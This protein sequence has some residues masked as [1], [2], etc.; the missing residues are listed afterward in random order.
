MWGEISF[1]P[2]WSLGVA[3]RSAASVKGTLPYPVTGT[4][5]MSVPLACKPWRCS[6][7]GPQL[8]LRTTP[9]RTR[10]ALAWLEA[11]TSL[12]DPENR[13]GVAH[14]SGRWDESDV[15][16]FPA[17]RTRCRCSNQT[18][19]GSEDDTT[20]RRL[21]VHPPTV[22]H[23]RA[24]PP[25]LNVRTPTGGRRVQWLIPSSKDNLLPCKAKTPFFSCSHFSGQ[26]SSRARVKSPYVSTCSTD[27]LCSTTA[28]GVWPRHWP[29]PKETRPFQAQVDHTPHCTFDRPLPIGSF[30]AMSWA[31]AMR[32]WFLM[33]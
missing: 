7:F 12:H 8:A 2:L 15:S 19:H 14:V 6:G 10:W 32:R 25:A 24:V 31:Y 20:R 3:A 22:Q 21:T 29:T 23:R 17:R 13:Q 27:P 26:A 4:G 30:R 18:V 11:L 5:S 28:T 33:K 16:S 9:A 1:L